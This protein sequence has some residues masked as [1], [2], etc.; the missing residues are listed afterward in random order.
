MFVLHKAEIYSANQN[1]VSE[2]LWQTDPDWTPC[3]QKSCSIA[4]LLKYTG[5]RKYHE[6]FMGQ[7]KDS[8]RS[9]KLLS[10]AKKDLT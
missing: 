8:E 7:D 6:Q 1:L 2:I 10:Q 4:P 9:L 5:N 3:A